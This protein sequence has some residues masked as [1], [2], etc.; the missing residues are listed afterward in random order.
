[1]KSLKNIYNIQNQENKIKTNNFL[2]KNLIDRTK[3]NSEVNNYFLKSIKRS[4][5]F[6]S[7]EPKNNN[8]KLN[9]HNINN[10][11]PKNNSKSKIKKK[12]LILD[13]DET[14]IHSYI[15]ND[16]ITNSNNNLLFKYYSIE[17]N[18][19]KYIKVIIRP[20][21]KEFFSA[22]SQK[23]E[24]V[25]F[26]ASVKN[27][28]SPLIDIIDI[29][30]ICKHRLFRDDCLLFNGTFIKNL[31][32]LNK[33]LKN[34]IIID[35]SSKSFLLHP[36]NGIKIKSFFNDLNDKELLY[37]IPILNFL[38]DVDDV[39]K[40]IKKIKDLNVESFINY[41][42]IINY[43]KN[44]SNKI[45]LNKRN[46]NDFSNNIYKQFL[47]DDNYFISEY[48]FINKDYQNEKKI[49]N[50][51]NLNLKKL[52]NNQKIKKN[53]DNKNI[54]NKNIINYYIINN[55]SNK[56]NYFSKQF[57]KFKINYSLDKNKKL[58][59]NNSFNS[60][61][62]INLNK[63]KINENTNSNLIKN[64]SY[65]EEILKKNKIKSKIKLKPDYKNNQNKILIKPL[66]FKN[67]NVNNFYK[68]S[69]YKSNKQINCNYKI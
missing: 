21:L 24:I 4:N 37:L 30:K 26:T 14:L 69:Q 58:H 27:Y 25:I 50:K 22:I 15:T 13:L 63:Y 66:N 48:N 51:S 17:D 35:N 11:L 5:S 9:S 64:Y 10:F 3:I 16:L 19:L 53:F 8:K 6:S 2:L 40:Y 55:N 44:I 43:L 1:M 57:F 12:T 32:L 61:L 34:V 28:A 67:K 52:K 18:S 7:I 60:S 47:S 59:Y 42:M 46:E 29:N 38:S 23:F 20:Y 54:D 49:K 68:L 36:E 41:E 33:N 39:R 45:V 62:N 65:N 56:F 31:D